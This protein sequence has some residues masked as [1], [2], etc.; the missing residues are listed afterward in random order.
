MISSNPLQPNHKMTRTHLSLVQDILT[1]DSRME[2]LL[3]VA[4]FLS[5][6]G[7][8]MIS[9]SHLIRKSLYFGLV[10][11]LLLYCNHKRKIGVKRSEGQQRNEKE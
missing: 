5:K 1:V 10:L 9:V 3:Q 8:P 4:Q 7:Y 2:S 6:R 11:L